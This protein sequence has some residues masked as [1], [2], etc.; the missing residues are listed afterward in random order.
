MYRAQRRSCSKTGWVEKASVI[1]AIASLA[2]VM[3]LTMPTMLIM[4]VRES[5]S[6]SC[7]FISCSSILKVMMRLTMVM[8]MT[9]TTTMIMISTNFTIMAIIASLVQCLPPHSTPDDDND[10]NDDDLIDWER[11][12]HWLQ[13]GSSP[14]NRCASRG[15]RR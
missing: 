5:V 15:T 1:L 9:I 6:H 2:Q 8:M 14:R 4:M 3:L 11:V 10:D 13:G 7:H 12:Q